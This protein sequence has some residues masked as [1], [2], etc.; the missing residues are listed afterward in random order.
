MVGRRTQEVVVSVLGEQFANW[1]MSDGYWV[2][3]QYDWRLRCLAH[4]ISKARGL[5][6]SLEAD[7]CRYGEETREVLETLMAAV[8]AA[9]EGP[10]EVP[11][12]HQHAAVLREFLAF[13]ERH[14]DAEHKKTR[15]LA[16]ELLNDWGTSGSSS[17][18]CVPAWSLPLKIGAGAAITPPRGLR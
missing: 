16:R 2:Y 17:T 14:A 3:R 8:Y 6:Q 4:L 12:R 11:L 13:C 9:Q 1:L 10:P 18:R 15:E 7:A 5:E